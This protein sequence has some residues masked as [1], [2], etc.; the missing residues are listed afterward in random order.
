MR[1]APPLAKRLEIVVLLGLACACGRSPAATTMPTTA[2]SPAPRL[3]TDDW[4]SLP[5]LATR[6]ITQVIHF[7]ESQGLLAADWPMLADG[8]VQGRFTLTE[9]PGL[10]RIQC[11]MGRGPVVFPAPMFEYYDFSQPDRICRHLQVLS[12]PSRLTVVQDWEKD[13]ETFL[14]TVSLIEN[15]TDPEP[16]TLRV[17]VIQDGRP[18]LN[19]AISGATLPQLRRRYPFEFEQ[20]L[21]PMFRQFRQEAAVF[22]VEDRIAWQVMAA[23]W[24]APPD[25]QARVQPLVDQLNSADYSQREQAQESLRQIGEPAALFL[26]FAV[27]KNWT[28]EQSARIHKFLAEFFVLTV[29]Q[30]N[31]LSVNIDFLLDCLASDDLSLQAAT[32]KHLDRV[33]KT[34]I[35][36]KLNQPPE[37]RFKAVEQLRRQLTDTQAAPDAGK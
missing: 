37:D 16:I 36:Y 11:A 23:D 22:S 6:P 1:M 2:P 33:L 24:I 9:M 8:P 17:Q 25:L 35:E 32:L 21:R 12:I 31:N 4:A 30:T 5:D 18:E 19:L 3:P 7:Y 26:H 14:K 13:D 15:I 10:A 34:K 20:Y 28:A 27:R 29:D